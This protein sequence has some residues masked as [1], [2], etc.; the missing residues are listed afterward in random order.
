M[1]D[2]VG[3]EEVLELFESRGWKLQKIYEPYRVFVKKGELPWLIPV[4][5]KKVDAEYV[6]KFKEFLEERG[7]I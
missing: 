6:K 3:F 2:H 1:K 4:H 5:N 7:E